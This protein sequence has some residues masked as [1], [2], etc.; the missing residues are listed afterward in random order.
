M[1]RTTARSPR[2]ASKPM[3]ME[4]ESATT[5]TATFFRKLRGKSATEISTVTTSRMTS[6]TVPTN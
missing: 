4:M 6:T 2:T 1:V 5:A 3:P